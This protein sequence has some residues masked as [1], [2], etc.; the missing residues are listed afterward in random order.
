[1]DTR[2]KDPFS[3]ENLNRR[4][5]KQDY[6]DDSNAGLNLLLQ[7]HD[8]HNELKYQP[9]QLLTSQGPIPGLLAQNMALNERMDSQN[10]MMPPDEHNLNYYQEYCRLFIAN[11]VLTTQMKDLVA[12]K[13]ELLNKLAKL[14]KRSKELNDTKTLDDAAEEKKKRFRRVASEIDRHY[15]CPVESCQKSYGSEGSLN[16]HVKLKHPSFDG[17][18]PTKQDVEKLRRDAGESASVSSKEGKIDL[19]KE[20]KNY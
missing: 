8:Q 5:M 13:N 10:M 14:E 3:Q 16:Q 4:S 6:M 17:P 18:L 9:K 2:S 1:M 11:V 19:K 7:A 20:A 12:E 15:R